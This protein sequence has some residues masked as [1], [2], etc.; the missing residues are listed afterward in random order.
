MDLQ[1]TSSLAAA[2]SF[3][4]P[5]TRSASELNKLAKNKKKVYDSDNNDVGK[6]TSSSEGY[7][8]SSD[9]FQSGEDSFGD[10]DYH[11]HSKQTDCCCQC[12]GLLKKSK[13]PQ[14]QTPQSRP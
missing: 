6:R 3:R 9:E 4:N 5:Q 7:F 8:R 14:Q 13:T 11:A 10:E 2:R 1:K 12:F